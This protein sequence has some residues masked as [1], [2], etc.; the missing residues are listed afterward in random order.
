[1]LTPVAAARSHRLY[2]DACVEFEGNFLKDLDV[3]GAR[4]RAPWV[5]APVLPV[6]SRATGRDLR[7]TVIVDNSPHAF[8]FH[9]DNGVPIESWFDDEADQ[10]VRPL[11]P[12]PLFT[13]TVR[14]SDR[15]HCARPLPCPPQ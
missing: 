14:G 6:A 13:C 1:M 12:A 10:E 8:A 11:I 7:R 4:A 5:L 3:L 9:V 15:C 2:R